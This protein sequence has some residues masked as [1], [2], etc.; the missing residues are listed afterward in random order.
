MRIDKEAQISK[1]D[2]TNEK[3]VWCVYALLEEDCRYR[4]TDLIV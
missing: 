1:L 3:S 4:I 2:D